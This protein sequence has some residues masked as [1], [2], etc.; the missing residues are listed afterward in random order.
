MSGSGRAE[1]VARRGQIVATLRFMTTLRTL[2]LALLSKG[3]ISAGWYSILAGLALLFVGLALASVSGD[4]AAAGVVGV[5]CLLA[6]LWQLERG[7]R[8]EFQRR[9]QANDDQ[10]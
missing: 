4:D 2:A 1:H 9:P 6:G 5:A 8:S 7:L 3:V 10:S